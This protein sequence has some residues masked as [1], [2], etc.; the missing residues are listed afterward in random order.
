M[1]KG[2]TLYFGS[3]D[4]AVGSNP[5]NQSVYFTN[6]KPPQKCGASITEEMEENIEFGEQIIIE[7]NDYDLFHVFCSVSEENRIVKYENYIFDFTNYNKESVRVCKS[8]SKRAL[9]FYQMCL[10]C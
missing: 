1:I 7:I 8:H 5:T 9:Y 3:G 2:N 6:M 10:A 4:I